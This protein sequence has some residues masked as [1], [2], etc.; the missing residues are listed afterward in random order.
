MALQKALVLPKAHA[1]FV[2]EETEVPEPGPGEILVEVHST[3]LNPVDWKA[4]ERGIIIKVYPAI[5]GNDA[6]GVVKKLGADVT[7]VDV[8]DRV[9]FQGF[10]DNRHATFQQYTIAPADR[11]AK[12]P[13]NLTL[14]QA[15]TLPV[16][17]DTAA[18]GL[19]NH[20]SGGGIELTPPWEEGGRGKYAGE[21]ILIVGGASA[22]GQQAIQF[23][24]LSGFS[25]IITTGS[26]RNAEFLHK[27]GATHVLERTLSPAELSAAIAGITR[28]PLRF[29]YDAVSLPET[30][31]A[32][33]AAL[34][35]GGKLVHVLFAAIDEAL[36]T[37]DKEHV[38]A[39]GN[40]HGPEQLNI[41]RSLYA[42]LTR[43]LEAGEIK[44][45]NVEVLPGGLA[46][47]PKG[48]ERLK[49]GVSAV[50][51]VARPQETA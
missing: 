24:K 46:G 19:Y 7:N 18:F 41:A 45:N 50:K 6:S 38:L 33:Y 47:I 40:V 31:S 32:A 27:L 48:L 1:Q 34:A 9:V 20:K 14:D 16:A 15:A 39:H 43:L 13:A 10:Y 35:P 30:Q 11:V 28:V 51:L 3:A 22:V 5:I 8:G 17:I 12:V 49:Q 37:P 21:P 36:L 42:N 23:A 26:Q 29:A 25:P 44:P 4:Q 2:V